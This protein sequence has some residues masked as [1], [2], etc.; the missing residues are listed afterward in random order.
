VL[1]RIIPRKIQG[2]IYH[3]ED[4]VK[5]I[6]PNLFFSQRED[7]I[8]ELYRR[9]EVGDWLI[10]T[11]VKLNPEM[12]ILLRKM[13]QNQHGIQKAVDDVEWDEYNTAIRREREAQELREYTAGEIYDALQYDLGLKSIASRS[14]YR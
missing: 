14:V 7:G 8:Y 1:Q 4:R 10:L 12:I 11:A 6:D 2:D 9:G 13:N 3:L 5:E